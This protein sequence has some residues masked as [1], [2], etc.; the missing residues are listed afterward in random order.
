MTSQA[1][2]AQQTAV[3]SAREA[4]AGSSSAAGMSDSM[5]TP[6]AS[7]P[8]PIHPGRSAVAWRMKSTSH[9]RRPTWVKEIEREPTA[10]R[11]GGHRGQRLVDVLDRRLEPESEQDDPGDHRLV[12]VAVV[13]AGEPRSR[14]PGRLRELPFRH[15]GDDVEI[16][17][18]E[19]GDDDDTEDGGG[20]DARGER[21]AGGSDAERDDRL[22]ESD[23][24][25]EP[26]PL[27]EV[28]RRDVPAPP[29]ADQGAPVERGEPDDPQ[30]RLRAAVDEPTT[31]MHPAP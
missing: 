27:R 16:G 28:C 1:M 13:V 14:G 19:R 3:T 4:S 21:E 10:E 25:D 11:H 30:G 15:D 17:P 9:R 23:D 29:P 8:G 2:S 7:L 26:V 24:D 20:D 22:S 31:R 5:T 6:V 18:P 12:Q